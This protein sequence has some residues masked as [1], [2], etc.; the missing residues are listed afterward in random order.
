MRIDQ[1]GADRAIRA[2]AEIARGRL[3][4]LAQRRADRDRP[5]RH[6]GALGQVAE[7]HRL[8][9]IRLP[10]RRL[11]GEIGPFAGQR[12]AGALVRPGGAKGQKV[13]E[14]EYAPVAPP[15]VRQMALQPHQLRDFH[16]RGHGAA[17]RIQDLVAARRAF[18]RLGDRPV[19]H[20]DD[21]VPAILAGGRDAGRP[22]V[23]VER[24]QRAGRIEADPDHLPGGEAGLGTRRLGRPADRPP[25]VLAVLLGVIG[26]RTRHGDRPLGPAEQAAADIEHTCA[27]AAGADVDT[28]DRP[29]RHSFRPPRHM[30]AAIVPGLARRRQ[31]AAPR[32][33]APPC[34]ACGQGDRAQGSRIDDFYTFR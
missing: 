23:L 22:V 9:E 27:R 24:H 8:Q 13:G 25:D 17:D 16:L 1:P 21:G 12:A 18:L 29:I 11:M 14:I 15:P 26:R 2:Q 3:G 30:T 31:A 7:P 34:H 19:I 10:S 4:E 5:C 32:R 20:P 6:G 28:Y 33:L